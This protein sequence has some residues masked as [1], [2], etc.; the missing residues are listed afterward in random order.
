MHFAVSRTCVV[1]AEIR[2]CLNAGEGQEFGAGPRGRAEGQ[3]LVP[4]SSHGII[5]NRQCLT[6]G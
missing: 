6:S 3:C 2:H 4:G 1:A 5:N